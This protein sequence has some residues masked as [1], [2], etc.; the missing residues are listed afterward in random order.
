MPPAELLQL[1]RRQPFIPFR[2]HRSD[3]IRYEIHHPELVMVGVASAV[4]GFPDPANP[5]LY[6][7]TEIIPLRHITRL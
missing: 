7:R 4:I 3:G 5:G 1:I 6:T 2:I